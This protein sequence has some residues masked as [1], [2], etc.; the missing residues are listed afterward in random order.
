MIVTLIVLENLKELYHA[1]DWF[2]EQIVGE[3]KKLVLRL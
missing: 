2:R 3:R 1:G